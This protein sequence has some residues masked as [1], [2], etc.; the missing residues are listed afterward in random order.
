M[1]PINGLR[2]VR[3]M[4]SVI[5][6][7]VPGPNDGSRPP[8]A[9]V[10][11]TIRAPRAWNNRTGWMTSPGSLPSYRWKRPWSMTT[12]RP[13]SRPSSSRPTW[14]GRGRRR[15]A[16][17][18]REGDG[19]GVLEVVRKT[20]EPGAQDDPDLGHERRAARARPPAS[21]AI[22]AGCSAGGIGR[23]G[24]TVTVGSDGHGHGASR[25]RSRHRTPEAADFVRPTE[26]STPGC[27]SRPVGRAP[28]SGR[29]ET[30]RGRGQ[31]SA[32]SDRRRTKVLDVISVPCDPVGPFGQ[33]LR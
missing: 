13:P 6:M 22:R 23:V 9:L 17:Q 4:W 18:L 24:S 7:S 21:A 14:P 3:L 1:G 8:A 19:H 16:G 27:R 32:R 5:T 12:G 2:P 26:V 29:G 31:R 28:R 33:D 30:A 10:S 15:P 25:V 11:T 20:A